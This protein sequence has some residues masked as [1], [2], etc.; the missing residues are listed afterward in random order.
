[1]TSMQPS[2]ILATRYSRALDI[3]VVV[4]VAAWDLAGAGGELLANLARYRSRRCRSPRGWCWR[5]W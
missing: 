2:A 5:R 3:A 1:M 4:A